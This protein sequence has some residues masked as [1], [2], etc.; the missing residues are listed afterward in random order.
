MKLSIDELSKYLGVAPRTIQ[1]WFKEGK[2]PLMRKGSEYQFRKSDIEKW[3]RRHHI[4]LNLPDEKE[5]VQGQETKISLSS[6]LSSGGIYNNISGHDLN[7][8]FNACIE[9]VSGIPDDFRQDLIDRLL[10]RESAHSTG[11]GNGIALPHPREPLAYLNDPMICA[12]FLEK[13]LDFGAIDNKPVSVLFF[14]LSPSLAI[15][16]N[17]LSGLSYCLRDKSFFELIMTVPEP[18]ILI[19]RIEK[20][21][22]ENPLSV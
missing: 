13:A 10:E 19:E 9:K 11:I 14:L 22:D 20:I 2:L 7:S 16:L 17:L 4:K 8:V 5:A 3:A 18:D 15:H 1:R 12:C 21:Q 6:A